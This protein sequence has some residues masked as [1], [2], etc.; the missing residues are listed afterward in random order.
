MDLIF[1][2][3]HVFALSNFS[4]ACE[5]FDWTKFAIQEIESCSIDRSDELGV[6][7]SVQL[8]DPISY[9]L[10]KILSMVRGWVLSM[11]DVVCSVV[12]ILIYIGQGAK[13]RERGHFH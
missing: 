1:E 8:I 10:G 13:W 5:V 11:C 4:V 7:G 2:M 12:E 6:E 3:T 9:L